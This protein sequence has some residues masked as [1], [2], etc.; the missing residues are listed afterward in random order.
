LPEPAA[1][2]DVELLD[3]EIGTIWVRSKEG[4]I[5]SEA[6]GRPGPWLVLATASGGM[7]YA[8]GSELSGSMAERLAA[9]IAACP[10]PEEAREQPAALEPCRDVLE[11]EIGRTEL[12]FGP[13]Y[14]MSGYE[15]Y[16]AGLPIASAQDAGTNAL[17]APEGGGWPADEWESLLRG[18]LGPWSLAVEGERAVSVCHCARLSAQAAEAGVW[19]HP[20][21]RGQGL[22]AAVTASW[23]RQLKDS[24]RA[25]F[26]S[27]SSD[28]LSSQRVAAR[29]GLR[30]IGWTWRLRKAGEPR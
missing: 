21:Y 4:R 24:G 29:L 10:P 5:V 19:T 27:T 30:E 2:T 15:S 12:S 6:N 3:L 16:R 22:A 28:N 17:R 13:S 1:R 14:L 26:Y 20:R 8:L 23:A 7:T 9:V 11:H 25:L 18:G